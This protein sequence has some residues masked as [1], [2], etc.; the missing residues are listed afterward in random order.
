ALHALLESLDGA[1][2]VLADIAKLLGAEDQ[3]DDQQH[4][5]PMP[6]AQSTHCSL[7]VSN[8][9]RAVAYQ[10]RPEALGSAEYVD[11]HVHHILAPDVAGVDDRAKTVAGT[12][13]A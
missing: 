3:H 12:L 5:Q 7:L 10:H 4:D 2:Q 13:L 6:D 8:R 1:A 9:L 11:V